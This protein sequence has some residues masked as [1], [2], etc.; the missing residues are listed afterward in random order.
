MKDEQRE[1][2]DLNSIVIGKA[3]PRDLSNVYEIS[4]KKENIIFHQTNL[5]YRQITDYDI[6]ARH[7]SPCITE[8]R[9]LS[10]VPPTGGVW[11]CAFLVA[12]GA[13]P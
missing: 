8:T 5:I 2:D 3:D 13:V 1:L 11:L 10:Y 9:Y 7:I 4:L 6:A 12:S